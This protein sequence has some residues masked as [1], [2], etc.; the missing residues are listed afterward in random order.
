MSHNLV[1]EIKNK[2]THRKIDTPITFRADKSSV[3]TN[4]ARGVPMTNERLQFV[5]PH[6]IPV[7]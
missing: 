1:T 5:H 7:W 3:I 6:P 4:C 2:L